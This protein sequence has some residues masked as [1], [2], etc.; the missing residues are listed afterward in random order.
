[1]SRFGY[2]ND[3]QVSR[4]TSAENSRSLY[5]TVRTESISPELTIFVKKKKVGIKQLESAGSRRTGR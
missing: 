2:A 1:L 4:I 3:G 5:C